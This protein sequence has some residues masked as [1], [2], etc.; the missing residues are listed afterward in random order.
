MT[1]ILGI[2]GSL[3][4]GSFNSALLRAAQ[5][6]IGGGVEL[7]AASIR[8]IPVYDGDIEAAGIPQEVA[9]LKEKIVQA[10]GLLLVSPEYNHSVPGSL[11]NAIDWVSRPASD[12]PRV[13]GDLPVA[14]MGASPGAFGTDLAQNAWWPVLHTLRT[15]PWFGGRLLVSRASKA[16]NEAG[17]L[18]DDELRK[19]LHDFVN[20]FARF[21]EM[22][23]KT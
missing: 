21:V 8:G 1:R 22:Y 11:K 12:I 9:A 14:V 23:A 2:S 3:R 5:A 4:S 7:E 15:R 16:F 6:E 18:V 19:R 20:G 13:F 10:D 17:D